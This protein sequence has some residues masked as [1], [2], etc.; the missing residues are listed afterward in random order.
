MAL[1]VEI[2][3]RAPLDAPLWGLGSKELTRAV[4]RAANR[5]LTGTRKEVSVGVRKRV[6]LKA[7]TIKDEMVYRKASKARPAAQ[8]RVPYEPISLKRY[9][10]RQIRSG[11]S[12]RVL[13]SAGR[14]KIKGGFKSKEL[15]DHAFL[16][17]GKARTP[18]N[19]LFGPTLQ[20]QVEVVMPSLQTDYIDPTFEKRLQEQI[21][22]EI[23]KA[24]RKALRQ[25]G[26]T[27]A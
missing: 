25:V 13:K 22:W 26:R 3:S 9:G 8:V 10:A 12:V 27:K 11:I 15:Y 24:R 2:L 19:M 5:T 17:V 21:A 6:N 16:R 20:S 4:V 7:K 14:S 23:E 1:T 18:I